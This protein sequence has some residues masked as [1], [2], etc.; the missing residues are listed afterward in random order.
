MMVKMATS[1]SGLTPMK[2]PPIGFT[3]PFQLNCRFR[4]WSSSSGYS[5]KRKLGISAIK[6][7]LNIEWQHISE[8]T[9][10][11]FLFP[12]TVFIVPCFVALVVHMVVLLLQIKL[13]PVMQTHDLL[14]ML[15]FSHKDVFK[16]T[17]ILPVIKNRSMFLSSL[18]LHV[19]LKLIIT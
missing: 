17:R 11:H 16:S 1:N 14:T 12:Y 5:L 19:K 2:E 6:N 8:S 18:I 13:H 15:G 4:T 9:W 3:K 10:I 7:P